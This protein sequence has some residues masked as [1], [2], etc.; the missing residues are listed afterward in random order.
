[1][2]FSER[3]G[4]KE[5][6]NAIQ[7][8]GMRP[9]L[10]VSL[11]NVLEISLWGNFHFNHSR[12]DK[13]KLDFLTEHLWFNYFKQPLNTRKDNSTD[14]IKQLQDYYF[15]CEWYEVYDFIESILNYC[16]NEDLT[17]KVNNVLERELS[18]YRFIN[19]CISNL[20]S[21]Q[22]IESVTKV[23]FDS[24]YPTV[25]AH[26]QRALEL[27]SDFKNPD[28]R[29]SIKESI[30]A[31]ESMVQIITNKT[32]A[33]LGDALKEI[34]KESSIH[35]ALKEAFSKLYGYTSDADGIRHAMIEVTQLGIE[36]ARYF[37]IS[38]SAFINF[39][40]SKDSNRAHVS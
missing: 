13:T 17:L 1:M 9:E 3:K 28:Y 2:K 21:P 20:T 5:I 4:Y 33:T 40:K 6:F 12:F 24:D 27:F 19:G 7:N 15:K 11:W 39:L 35:P 10:R 29:N 31:V 22:E 34:E 14:K 18:G 38:C 36:D 26:L 8:E 23:L 37:L 25:Q 30:S 16:E 32:K